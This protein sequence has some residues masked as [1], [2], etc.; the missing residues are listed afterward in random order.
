MAAIYVIPGQPDADAINAQLQAELYHVSLHHQALSVQMVEGWWFKRVTHELVHGGTG[1]QRA[2]IDAQISDIQESLK[3]D[4]LPIELGDRTHRG[5]R[6]RLGSTV[7][8]HS[9]S[10][11]G[12]A[13]RAAAFRS[14]T[15]GRFT[16]IMRRPQL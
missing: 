2:E 5:V 12:R 6:P 13:L 4:S 11:R 8:Q 3:R 10:R 1:I 7:H 9:R 14:A 16:A 15:G